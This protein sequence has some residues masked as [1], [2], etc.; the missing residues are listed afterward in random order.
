MSN[1]A[2][3]PQ[4]PRTGV[5]WLKSLTQGRLRVW[6]KWD[7]HHAQWGRACCI[8]GWH[9]RISAMNYEAGDGAIDYV[10]ICARPSCAW[11]ERVPYSGGE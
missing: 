2:G 11:H 1:A 6:W 7:F 10:T 8:C 9:D 4:S 3:V 5:G